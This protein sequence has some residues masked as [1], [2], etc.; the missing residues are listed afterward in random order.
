MKKPAQPS[1]ILTM[2]V[3]HEDKLRIVREARKRGLTITAFLLQRSA[4][5]TVAMAAGKPELVE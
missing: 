1:T 2:R 4:G 3:P 5:D